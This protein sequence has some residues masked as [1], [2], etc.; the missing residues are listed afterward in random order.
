MFGFKISF[1]MFS[2]IIQSIPYLMGTT[3]AETASRG[4]CFVVV[5][6]GGGFGQQCRRRPW[7]HCWPSVQRPCP[8]QSWEVEFLRQWKQQCL[9]LVLHLPEENLTSSNDWLA[10]LVR[11]WTQLR[12]CRDEGT[13]APTAMFLAE[14][15]A[16]DFC[17]DQCLLN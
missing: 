15:E 2:H 8:Y 11:C 13:T 17:V 12:C 6:K 3:G 1:I 7:T 14:D 4:A 9:L 5:H 16:G 10:V